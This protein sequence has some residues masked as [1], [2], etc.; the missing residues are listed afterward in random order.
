M[1]TTT[2][3]V[4]TPDLLG[5]PLPVELMN[6]L[7][8]GPS[9][10]RDVLG[11]PAGAAAWINAIANR[12][13]PAA[14][15][16]AVGGDP[17]AGGLDEAAVRPITERLRELRD[18]LRRLAAEVTVDPRPPAAATP[19]THDDAVATLNRL[20]ALAPAWPVVH[21]PVDGTPALGLRSSGRPVERIV[22]LI[23]EQAA[24]LFTGE[25]RN[26][27]VPCLAPGCDRYFLK[28]HARQQWCSAACGN[29]AR[30]ARHYQ[31]HH[32]PARAPRRPAD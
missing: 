15:S 16:L 19:V 17:T 20:C 28:R 13:S 18:A 12:L 22:S 24:E 4:A 21:W 25:L 2:E 31:R 5:E 10:T 14:R 23:A 6:T 9:G 11:D 3:A 7:T 30:V 29:R 26:Q 1:T 32:G 27:L 8:V